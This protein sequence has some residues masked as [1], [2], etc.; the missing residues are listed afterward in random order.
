[1]M[2]NATKFRPAERYLVSFWMA[3]DETVLLQ[4][5]LESKLKKKKNM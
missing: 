2:R 4:I 3:T 1:M 5:D